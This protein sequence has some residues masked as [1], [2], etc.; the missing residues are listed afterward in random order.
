MGG[1]RI[2]AKDYKQLSNRTH[3]EYTLDKTSRCPSMMA[4]PNNEEHN[5]NEEDMK[6]KSENDHSI[7]VI[8]MNT[9]TEVNTSLELNKR[10][11]TSNSNQMNG[12]R[13]I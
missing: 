1:H 7:T 4:Q 13:S 8:N 5:T 11:S 2:I 6:W 3:T 10:A 9:M 12:N